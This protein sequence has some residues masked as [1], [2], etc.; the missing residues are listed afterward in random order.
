MPLL[1]VDSIQSPYDNL[2]VV[3]R[4]SYEKL[5]DTPI[6]RLAQNRT[7]SKENSIVNLDE[8]EDIAEE[9]SAKAV[10]N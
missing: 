8:T 2:I 5:P 6:S 7:I 1:R 9:V 3:H 10:S 4:D